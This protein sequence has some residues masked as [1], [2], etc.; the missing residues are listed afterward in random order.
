MSEFIKKKSPSKTKKIII[1]TSLLLL[2][3]IVLG[4]GGY[5]GYQYYSESKR[6]QEQKEIERQR[7][8]ERNEIETRRQE[9]YMAYLQDATEVSKQIG[10]ITAGIEV[11]Y[12]YLEFS[13]KVAEINYAY[14]KFKEKYD[15]HPT[16]KTYI[17]YRALDNAGEQLKRAVT[18][19]KLKNDTD[20]TDNRSLYESL[21]QIK[22]LASTLYVKLADK[23]ID[24]K[25]LDIEN[26]SV[27]KAQLGEIG[28]CYTVELFL[29]KKN[30]LLYKVWRLGREQILL[31]T[32][33]KFEKGG[34]SSDKKREYQSRVSELK[35]KAENI[36]NEIEEIR[37]N[38]KELLKDTGA[39]WSPFI[40]N[41]DIQKP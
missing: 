15:M 16:I 6:E 22:F 25:R 28:M 7:Q 36:N 21:L 41:M 1:S 32:D 14:S 30:E 38:Y 19:W 40:R 23:I 26:D 3:I 11:G 29:M 33:I 4:I 18:T 12:N 31:E 13:K 17:S 34:I 9:E 39:L 2:L 27:L 35:E 10:A 37:K 8:E 5:V 24:S 20:N